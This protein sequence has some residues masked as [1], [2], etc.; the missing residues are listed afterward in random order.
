M[1]KTF[2]WLVGMIGATLIS[3]GMT[4]HAREPDGAEE[5]D[6]TEPGGGI[7]HAGKVTDT[8]SSMDFTQMIPSTL[9]RSMAFRQ[10]GWHLWDPSIV[11]DKAGVHHLFY[12]RWPSRLG[13]DAWCT[14]AE[15]ARAESRDGIR[16]YVFQEVVL[17]ARGADFWD[18]HATFNTC[19]VQIQDTYYLYYTGNRGLP[20]WEADRRIAGMSREWWTHRNNQRIGVAV[21]D[22]PTGPWTRR[23]KPLVDIGPGIIGQGIINVPNLVVK[24]EG[25]FRLYYKT[26]GKGGKSVIHYGADADNPLGPFVTHPHI[27]VDKNKLMPQVKTPFKFHI[28]D[29]F[30]WI[31]EGR[32]Y[33]IVKDHDAPYL[34]RHGKSLLL[35]E[36]PDGRAWHPAA[37]DLVTGFTIKWDDGGKTV[38]SRLEMP[39]ILF[40]SGRPAILSLAGLAGSGGESFIVNIPLLSPSAE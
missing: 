35:F 12:S 27:M 29:H 7:S 10:E 13:F 19:V 16:P 9:S 36:S 23:D 8:A 28:D 33:A 20:E 24:P 38:C 5:R 17:P 2:P 21:A 34:T 26:L 37:N 18:G 32:Y 4:A 15:I 31:Q 14:H 39:K 1:I 6:E 22:A 40:R 11:V 3:L 25:G 30:E